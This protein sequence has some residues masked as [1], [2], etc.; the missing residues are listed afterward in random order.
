MNNRNAYIEITILILASFSP[1]LSQPIKAALVLMLLVV[2]FK[3]LLKFRKNKI[4]T[5]GIFIAIFTLSLALDLRNISSISQMNILNLYFPMCILLGYVI[6]EKYTLTRF[7]YLLDKIIIVLAVFSLIGVLIY[8]FIPNLVTYLPSYN[9]YHTTHRTAYIFNVLTNGPN[10]ILKRNAGIAWEPGAFQFIANLG[11]Y[12]YLKTNK[13]ISLFRIGIYALAIITTRSTAGILIFMAVTFKLFIEDKKARVLILSSVLI[14]GGLILEE[15][16]Y[17]FRYKLFGSFAFEIRLQPLLHAF[18][19]GKNYFMGMGNSGFD[20]YYR[21]VTTPP[22]DSFGQIFIRYGY[23]LFIF[24]IFQL[25]RL[26][27]NQKVLFIILVITLSSQNIWFFP[28]VTPFYFSF[29]KNEIGE[30]NF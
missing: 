1:L 23:P 8:T 5:L 4:I 2:N 26:I 19:E 18:N 7:Y 15:L 21:N 14:F 30:F 12:A 24:I 28:L 10:G 6:S 29:N 9:Y 16:I 25:L 22:W 3:Y 17:Q 27:K 20:I 11:I 13:K